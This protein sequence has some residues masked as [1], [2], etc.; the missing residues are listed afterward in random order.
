MRNLICFNDMSAELREHLGDYRLASGDPAG[1]PDFE[2][3][4]SVKT[5]AAENA[6]GG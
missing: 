4:S 5:V 1:Q 3:V 6:V 2:Q